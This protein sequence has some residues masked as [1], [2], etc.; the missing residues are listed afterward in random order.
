[1]EKEKTDKAKMEKVKTVKAKME[2]EKIRAR[3]HVTSSQK[4]K[5]DATR[6]NIAKDTTEC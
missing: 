6:D 5:M 3:T 4:Q 2:K 1:M